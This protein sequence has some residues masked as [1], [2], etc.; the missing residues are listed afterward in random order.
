MAVNRET[1]ATAVG[2]QIPAWRIRKAVAA[3]ESAILELTR[4]LADFE[5]PPGRLPEDIIAADHQQIRT[6]LHF[7]PPGHFLLVAE[8]DP[9]RGTPEVIG[10]ALVSVRR[11]FYTRV[12]HAHLEVLAV[13]SAAEG[14]GVGGAL[15]DEAEFRARTSGFRFIT[16]NVFT[17]NQR[18]RGFYEARN[19]RLE[20]LA[21]HKTLPLNDLRRPSPPDDTRIES[22][23]PGDERRLLEMAGRLADFELPPWRSE[24]EIARCK[25]ALIRGALHHQAGEAGVLVARHASGEILGFTLMAPRQDAFSGEHHAHLEILVVSEDLEGTGVADALLG[26][27]EQQAAEAG[28][29]VMSLGLFANNRRARSFY[30]RHGYQPELLGY[31]KAL[32]PDAPA[33][34]WPR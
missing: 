16:L 13:A 5:L 29:P 21:W 7:P 23:E 4:R 27:T 14:H 10:C 28:Y 3:D 1:D 31:R 26:T 22:G 33:S 11:D 15:L 30:T 24:R 2:G 19:Y 12:R 20:T 32:D 6:T 8:S 25:D 18:A 17:G 9:H 34:P